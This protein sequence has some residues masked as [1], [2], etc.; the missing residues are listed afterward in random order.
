[1]RNGITE[2]TKLIHIGLKLLVQQKVMEKLS[3]LYTSTLKLKHIV[4]EKKT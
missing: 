3:E 1:M 2:K 4:R